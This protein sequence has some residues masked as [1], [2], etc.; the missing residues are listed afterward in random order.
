[1]TPVDL[2]AAERL[3]VLRDVLGPL[4]AQGAIVRRPAVMAWAER[5]QSDRRLIGTLADLRHRHGGAPLVVRL[6]PRSIVL[7][8]R[9]DDVARLLQGTPT[10]FSASTREKS[11]ALGQFVP[12]GVLISSAAAREVRRP[13][14]EAALDTGRAVHGDAELITKVVDREAEQ[15]LSDARE[16][17]SL[18]WP[19]FTDA[20]Q[21][22]V[23]EITLGPA[24]RDDVALTSMLTAL[25]RAANW[26]YLHPRRRRLRQELDARLH[27]YARGA[28]PRTLLGRAIARAE[29][30]GTTT[31]ADPAGQVGHWL[32]AFDAAGITVF[33]ALAVL[34][35]RPEDR[36]RVRAE[37]E[38]PS[39]D[40]T[41][42]FTR[43]CVLETVRLWPTTLVVLRESTEPTAWGGRELPA[44]TGFAVASAFFH[45][46]RE[47][48]DFADAFTPGAWLDGRAADDWG[49]VP[50]SGG[51]AVC[52]GRDLVL[53]VASR[54]L[55]R[56][57]AG[58]LSF[59]RSVYLARQ[60]LPVTV[61][62]YGLRFRADGARGESSQPE[63]V[64]AG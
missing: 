8:S 19:A 34:L 23:R 24:A 43:A 9:P 33:R 14:N 47:R 21:R 51:P 44:G 55:T 18:D 46:D 52:A 11:A 58:D 4:V 53:L 36:D 45:R 61:D 15:L 28:P 35:S 57:A 32:F 40:T 38:D 56:L 27:L 29:E 10:P 62:H 26:S 7:V 20:F 60:A 2:S 50:F 12:H 41:L 3:R 48:L 13:V 25:R 1:M 5:R 30:D 6:G 64:A 42:P 63:E 22:C 16:R 17:G 49:I 54:W 37:G 39:S 31:V 59:D